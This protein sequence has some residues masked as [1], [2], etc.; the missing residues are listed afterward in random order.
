VEIVSGRSNFEPQN[1]PKC[2][3]VALAML[4]T[5]GGVAVL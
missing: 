2:Q 1:V 4:R 5:L 3:E